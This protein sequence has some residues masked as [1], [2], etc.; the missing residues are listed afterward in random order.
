MEIRQIRSATQVI[1]ISGVKFLTDP[2]LAPKGTYMGFPGSY[3][4]HLRQPT[5]ELVVPIDE[6]VDVDAVI[7]THV[8]PDHWDRYAVENIPGDKP[9]FT[10]HFG[11]RAVVSEGRAQIIDDKGL[12]YEQ[13]Q[14]KTFTDVRI[15]TGNPEFKGVK[16]HKVPGQHGSDEGVQKAYD[17]ILE[18]CGLVFTCPGEKTLYVAGDTVWNEY[19]EANIAEY[20]PDIIVVNACAALFNITGPILMGPQDVAAVCKAAPNATVI[21]SHMEAVNHATTS[22]AELRAHLEKVGLSDQVL[23]PADGE[24]MSFASIAQTV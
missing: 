11:D 6:I 16:L 7:V 13:V 12:W 3:N 20:Q 10:Q 18:V 21:A 1:E 17:L 5:A 24:T 9:I 15:L 19:V 23:I 22:R 4:E 14:G 8:H 2:W